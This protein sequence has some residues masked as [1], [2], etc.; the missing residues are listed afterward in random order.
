MYT[1]IV[2][3]DMGVVT[4]CPDPRRS[5]HYVLHWLGTRDWLIATEDASSSHC[6]CVRD[7]HKCTLKCIWHWEYEI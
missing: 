5:S 2:F 7:L 1:S 4:W 3:L 6:Q